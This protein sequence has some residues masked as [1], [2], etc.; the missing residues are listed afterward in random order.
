M[1][2]CI[3]CAEVF[4]DFPKGVIRCPACAYKI[5]FKV[6]DQVAKTIKAR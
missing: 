4:D 3:K 6:R 5:V 1:Y 2:K